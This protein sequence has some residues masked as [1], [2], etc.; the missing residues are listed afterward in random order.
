[1]KAR[2]AAVAAALVLSSC[3]TQFV[4]GWMP[5][6]QSTSD[7]QAELNTISAAAPL[8]NEV[9]PF[10]YAAHGAAVDLL[11][12]G[13]TL[14]NTVASLRAAG[15]KVIPSIVD[16]NGKGVM[17][18]ILADPAQRTAHV[19]TI[20]NLVVAK[21]YDGIDIDYEVFAFTDGRTSWPA[22]KPNWISFVTEL[23]A[24]L[25]AQGKLLSVTVPPVWNDGAAG[26]TVYAQPEIIPIVD[27]LRLMVYDWTVSAASAGPVAPMFWVDSVI[28]Y[29][30]SITPAGQ[31]SKLQLGVPAYGRHWALNSGA[32][33]PDGARFVDSVTMEEAGRL[34]ATKGLAPVRAN[35]TGSVPRTQAWGEMKFTWTEVVSGPRAATPAPTYT[36]PATQVGQVNGTSDPA[37]TP[38]VRL[39]PPSGYVTCTITHV[40]YY[41]DEYAIRERAELA[42]ANGWE[43]IYIWALG[44]ENTNTWTV[45]SQIP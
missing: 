2:W 14:D 4:G 42:L 27:R 18:G 10:W 26:Y 34:A 36:P 29:T 5:W 1:M 41:S 21:G 37:L 24:A 28:A 44:Y 33:C 20:T 3:Q 30:N 39:N 12:N 43:G 13:T 19:Q 45:L 38:A 35:A 16:G 32:I 8:M 17:A 11:G 9:S 7:R 23:G 25:H 15:L 31:R 40:V 22:T 6:W